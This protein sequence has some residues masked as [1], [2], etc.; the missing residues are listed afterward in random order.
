MPERYLIFC[1]DSHTVGAGD[2]RAL[3]WTGR[4]AAASIAA[5]V[6]VTPYNLGVR[7]QTSVEVAARWRAEAAPRL[8]D[9]GSDSRAVFAFGVNDVSLREGELRCSRE[10]SLRALRSAL[11]GA[12]ELGTRPFLVGPAAVDEEAAN[13]RIVALSAAF[14]ELCEER[15]VPFAPLAEELRR[16]HVWRQEV[17]AGDGAHPGAGGYE[18][19]ARLVLAAGWLDWL[20]S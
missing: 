4:V 19:I 6:P 11:D 13:K 14:E 9:D 10:E 2:P 16:S 7:G 12:G 1:G 3:G 18:E 8:P 15:R 17:A 20:R 5:G